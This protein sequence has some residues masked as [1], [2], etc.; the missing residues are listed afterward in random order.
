MHELLPI[1]EPLFPPS[2]PPR[3][4]C[5]P[6]L[7]LPG[8][9]HRLFRGTPA[10]GVLL[11]LARPSTAA[12][13]ERSTVYSMKR[14]ARAPLCGRQGHEPRSVPTL[15]PPALAE[16][17]PSHMHFTGLWCP[18]SP[19]VPRWPG[20]CLGLF[21]PAQSSGGLGH[22]KQKL[23]RGLLGLNPDSTPITC[24]PCNIQPIIYRAVLP[25]PRIEGITAQRSL[26]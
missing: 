16:W 12:P 26:S 21:L 25:L 11:T 18:H 13:S 8:H 20:P 23:R 4:P 10:P 6:R 5:Q 19:G 7:I 14:G 15:A 2:V 9:R 22:G 1:S 3:I 24:P 17:F